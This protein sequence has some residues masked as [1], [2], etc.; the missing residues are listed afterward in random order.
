MGFDPKQPRDDEGQWTEGGSGSAKGP[1]SSGNRSIAKIVI[2]D[3]KNAASNIKGN[4]AG[5]KIMADF[6]AKKS[7]E[8]AGNRE[9]FAR[10]A[11]LIREPDRSTAREKLDQRNERIENSVKRNLERQKEVLAR[12]DLKRELIGPLK[13]PVLEKYSKGVISRE[14]ATRAIASDPKVVSASNRALRKYRADPDPWKTE[15]MG[16]EDVAHLRLYSVDNKSGNIDY[17]TGSYKPR[18]HTLN[19][20]QDKMDV[21]GKV[22]SDFRKDA[23]FHEAQLDRHSKGIPYIRETGYK[24]RPKLN[25]HRDLRSDT[26]SVRVNPARDRNGKLIIPK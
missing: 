17:R 22:E 14:E 6:N 20:L 9:L 7:A 2:S 26:A 11:A 8:E 24:G 18:G 1:S 10:A 13:D 4:S 16:P 5:A 12:T 3:H 15:P 19:H 21:A 23:I 25:F